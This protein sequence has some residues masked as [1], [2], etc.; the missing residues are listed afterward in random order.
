MNQKLYLL[1][2]L[3]LVTCRSAF[4]QKENNIWA[5]GHQAGLD[6]NGGSPVPLNTSMNTDAGCA[7][8]ASHSGALLFYTNGDT[9]WNRNHVP[10]LN[11]TGLITFSSFQNVVIA[12]FINDTTKFYIF[13]LTNSDTSGSL[14]YS[15]VD[16]TL[17]GGLGGVVASQKNQL[18]WDEHGIEK[19]RLGG[20]ITTVAG[21]NCNL[22]LI[23]HMG[24]NPDGNNNK[25]VV[26]EITQ[27]G[28][29][30]SP[31]ISQT[32][33]Y[34][35]PSAYVT[36]MVKVAPDRHKLATTTFSLYS[37]NYVT[38][39]YSA[40][41]IHNFDPATG[42]VSN[43]LTIDSTD[44][45]FYN[46][47]AT[48]F[49]PDG[50]KLYSTVPF[51]PLMVPGLG[52]IYQ[53]DLSLPTISAI[54]LSKTSVGM[55]AFGGDI[56][57]GP[58][59]KVY[60]SLGW[61]FMPTFTID[62]IDAP[63]AAGAACNYVANAVSLLPG[64]SMAACLPNPVAYPIQDTVIN[65]HDTLFC[66]GSRIRF[67]APDGYLRYY[68]QGEPV[69][70]TGFEVTST[71]TYWLTYE[72]HCQRVTDTFH[73]RLLE[74][75]SGLSDTALCP[76]QFPLVL[77]ASAANPAGTQYTWQD[78]T[79][80]PVYTAQGAGACSIRMTYQGCTHT[81]QFRI[82]EKPTPVVDL[83]ADTIIC[84][85]RPLALNAPAADVFLWQDEST[86]RGMLV[87]SSG[88]YWVQVVTDG[89]HGGDSITVTV[90][91]CDCKAYVPNAFSPNGDGLNDLFA[92]SVICGSYSVNYR[93]SI[94]NRWGQ[95]VFY[96][97]SPAKGW[98]GYYNGLPAD[99][100][101]YFFTLEYGA[102]QHKERTSR[103]GEVTLLR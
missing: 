99:A 50:S 82:T 16:M 13:H 18:L 28:I 10:M 17:N 76:E 43:S 12:P 73:V 40:L 14:Y 65:I 87:S 26:Y 59:G 6:F 37:Y 21:D 79:S 30:T 83:G 33:A 46:I 4:A 94:Y 9:V 84:K 80:G 32:G 48:G 56:Q 27:A 86:E 74:L 92:P 25:F 90:N 78:G 38:I 58:D 71:G 52:G 35:G 101:V 7:S 75:G 64:T 42:V 11:G 89:C 77:D 70:N 53:F 61:G 51:M 3:L 93:L 1:T 98:D 67:T 66:T 44:F 68:W 63:D 2:L 19:G 15:V 36:G 85:D 45:A 57:A 8:V 81:E 49:S 103:K 95:R 23:T 22:W 5:F 29:N 54:R 102:D 96:S 39:D 60:V 47:L 31:V 69:A 62:R 97:N 72:N 88:L 20:M 24:G 55:G 91:D 100:G 34:S 41:E